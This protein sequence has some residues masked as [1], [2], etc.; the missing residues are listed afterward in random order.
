MATLGDVIAALRASVDRLPF[1]ELANALDEAEE[2]HALIE[3]AAAG[4]GQA[5]FY[6]VLEWFRLV[7]E[8]IGDLQRT[9]SAIQAN[10]T[11]TANRLEGSGRTSEPL[12]PTAPAS[13]ATPVAKPI[14]VRAAEL[15]T[16]LPARE[17]NNYKTAGVWI[18]E[19]GQE[20]EPLVSGRDEGYTEAKAML[21]DLRIGPARG[22]LLTAAHVEVKL[23][24]HLRK[25]DAKAVTLVINNRPCHSDMWS[26]DT[27]LPR[28][29]KPGQAI[30]IY[31]P[32]GRKTYRG[33]A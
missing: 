18:D 21:K 9:L 29:L 1:S 10:V 12:P 16:R 17:G 23:V 28:L 14:E 5:E 7:V 20:R 30:T 24:A 22:D 2:A 26:C 6:Q 27:L 32:G 13:P 11:D 25:T 15:L 4:S 8:G 3:Q 19:H 33:E 31:W